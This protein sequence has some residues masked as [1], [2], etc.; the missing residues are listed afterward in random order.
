MSSSGSVTFSLAS[1]LSQRLLDDL[2]ARIVVLVNAMAKAHQALAADFLSLAA[3]MNLR[4]VVAG[5]MD[6]LEHFEHRLVGAA[7][8]RAPQAHT[9]AAALANRLAWLDATMRTVEVEQFCSWSACSRKIRSSAL[10]T[11]G[12]SS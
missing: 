11:S 6:V 10:T 4:A 9:P 3:A 8:Q 1:S 12:L 2:G 7:V 5:L